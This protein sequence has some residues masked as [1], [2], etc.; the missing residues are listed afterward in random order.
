MDNIRQGNTCSNEGTFQVQGHQT[1]LLGNGAR[2]EEYCGLDRETYAYPEWNEIPAEIWIGIGFSAV[3]AL[4]LQWGTTGAALMIA[5]LTPAKGLGC[6]SG[7]YL[8]YGTNATVAWSLLAM[9]SL[10]SHSTMLRYQREKQKKPLENI[11]L[12]PVGYSGQA[13]PPSQPPPPS[14]ASPL[15]QASSPAQTP[16]SRS[17]AIWNLIPVRVLTAVTRYFGKL[18]V[19]ANAL[20]LVVANLFEFTGGFDN[21]WCK[22]DT[23]GLRDSGWVV[24]FRSAHDL[25]QAASLQWGMGLMTSILVCVVTFGAFWGGCEW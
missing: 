17:A 13:L 5:Y 23:I 1:G 16:L 14:Q 9:S 24:L 12:G 6:R 8:L 25:R 19:V 7:A 11:P 4:G 21:C 15:P 2:T 22:S 18:L 3:L 20:F 10:L